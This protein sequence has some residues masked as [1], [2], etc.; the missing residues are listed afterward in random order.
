VKLNSNFLLDESMDPGTI[1]QINNYR[2]ENDYEEDKCYRVWVT[3]LSSDMP[4]NHNVAIPDYQEK[5]GIG[6][7]FFEISSHLKRPD[8]SYKDSIFVMENEDCF[9]EI[10]EKMNT[11]PILLIKLPVSFNDER[12]Y[13]IGNHL[14]ED[15]SLSN[16]YHVFVVKGVTEEITT[17]IASI[18]N[19]TEMELEELK[20]IVLQTIK[21]K[22][23]E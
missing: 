17:E 23:D 14:N 1:I 21:S 10:K 15:E 6:K 9:D 20:Q 11:K 12:L 19:T 4:H 22:Q 8:G 16:D 3:C 13:I 5:G 2:L 18:H 7:T